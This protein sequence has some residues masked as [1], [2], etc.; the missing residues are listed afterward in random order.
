MEKPPPFRWTVEQYENMIRHGILTENNN[1]ELI[2]GEIVP[3]M[4]KGD[5][6]T[7]CLKILIRLFGPLSDRT[8]LSVQDPIYLAD[9]A[10]EPDVVLLAF[11][12]DCYRSVKPRAADALLV[13][14]VADSSLKYDR[15]VKGPLY[16][17]NGIAEYWIVNLD[18]CLEVFRQPQPD[19]TYADSQVLRSGDSLS[20]SLL[21]GVSVAV[22]E[23]LP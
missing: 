9:S 14:E 22:A 15:E 16:A 7:W 13:V 4:P 6:H 20:L 10:P 21:P 3:K 8:I 19:G 18:G 17:E 1:V 2:R 11:R 12:D 23:F 5:L